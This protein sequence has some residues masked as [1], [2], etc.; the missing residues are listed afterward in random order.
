MQRHEFILNADHGMIH[1]FDADAVESSEEL[2]CSTSEVTEW[3]VHTAIKAIPFS[4]TMH[5]ARQGKSPVAVE[6]HDTVPPLD[7]AAWDHVTEC[8]LDLPSGRLAIEYGW[9]GEDFPELRAAPGRYRM[10]ACHAK[11]GSIGF[12][13][14][15][16]DDHYLVAFWPSDDEQLVVLKQ[17]TYTPPA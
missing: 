8:S 4:A 11:L 7:L 2:A 13:P 5:T 10:R 14:S 3:H 12:L 1:F 17:Y 15:E 9:G 16:G 6:F